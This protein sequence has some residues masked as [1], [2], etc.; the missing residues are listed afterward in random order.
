MKT[1]E[2]ASSSAMET[3]AKESMGKK[4]GKGRQAGTAI[5]GRRENR[6]RVHRMRKGKVSRDIHKWKPERKTRHS[7]LI[8]GRKRG[9][10]FGPSPEKL[11]ST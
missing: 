8:W 3:E 10:A 9:S 4:G 2:Q 5:R 11:G 6:Q 7:F 1:G